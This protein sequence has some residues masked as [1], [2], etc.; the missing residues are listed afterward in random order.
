MGLRGSFTPTAFQVGGIA[1]EAIAARC[2]QRDWLSERIE[3]RWLQTV[4]LFVLR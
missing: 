2:A 1:R 3:P 4:D